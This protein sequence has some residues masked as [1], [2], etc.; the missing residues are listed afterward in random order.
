MV[1][2]YGLI[3]HLYDEKKQ[4]SLESLYLN[5]DSKT[6]LLIRSIIAESLK[7]CPRIIESNGADWILCTLA[8]FHKSEDDTM[9]IYQAIMSN[10]DNF[11]IGLLTEEIK[12]KDLNKISDECLIGVGFFR[13]YLEERC[14]RKASPP[15]EYYSQA[16]AA[17]FDRLGFDS[18]AED[19]SYWTSFIENEFLL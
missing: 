17:A 6:Q 8:S 16:G 18:I 14:K 15:V 3:K 12:W 11:S 1:C 19:F 5:E 4:K 7:D 9:R 2:V 10:L 13:K